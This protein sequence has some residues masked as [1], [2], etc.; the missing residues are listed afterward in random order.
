MSNKFGIQDD[1]ELIKQVNEAKHKIDVY[2]IY[3]EGVLPYEG[4]RFMHLIARARAAGK[5]V[6]IYKAGRS[7][8]GSSAVAGH[9]A[10]MAGSYS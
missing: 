1:S 3:V 10:S 5:I 9:T 4:I 2:G 8:E 7:K 6:I